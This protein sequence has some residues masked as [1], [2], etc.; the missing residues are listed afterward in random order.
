ML[1]DRILFLY[2]LRVSLKFDVF[3][4][5]DFIVIS[6]IICSACC[7]VYNNVIRLIMP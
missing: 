4:I 5:S 2:C 7:S 3:I 6:D 1:I